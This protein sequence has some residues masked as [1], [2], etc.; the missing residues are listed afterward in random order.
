VAQPA[1]GTIRVNPGG[2]GDVLAALL[3]VS[4][5]AAAGIRRR[6]DL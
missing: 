6:R 2:A 5:I 3:I 1:L 4:A